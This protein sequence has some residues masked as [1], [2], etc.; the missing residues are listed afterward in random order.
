MRKKGF[1]HS[2]IMPATALL[3]VVVAASNAAAA[4]DASIAEAEA[5]ESAAEVAITPR[6]HSRADER[7]GYGELAVGVL[8]APAR[9]FGRA[10]AAAN[11]AALG[12][13][14]TLGYGVMYAQTALILGLKNVKPFYP[15]PLNPTP[16]DKFY[17][18]QA[19]HTVPSSLAFMGAGYGAALGL[20]E[21]FGGSADPAA[22]WAGYSAAVIMP[23]FVTM[24]IP[25]TTIALTMRN[26]QEVGWP[27][28][29]DLGRQIA[30]T[31]WSVAL[32]A[33]AVTVLADI[34]WWQGA[35]IGTVATGITGALFG[36]F[37]R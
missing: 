26:P 37:Y 9:T 29:V 12:W 19:G 30:G 36:M 24:W 21:L 18:V 15:H 27:E 2:L 5:G 23:T 1:P 13:G 34:P 33:V 7:M 14:I 6:R 25:E 28:W 22:L 17:L 10:G 16:D 8:V 32:S 11:A 3:L 4:D 31:A 35:I 20:I